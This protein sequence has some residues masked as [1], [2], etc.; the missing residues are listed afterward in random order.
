VD[1]AQLPAPQLGRILVAA[2]LLDEEQVAQAL[3]EQ[4]QTG[5]RLGEIIVQR[6]FI[7]G[8]ALANALAEQY[9]GVVKTEYG[10]ASGLGGVVA[11]RAASEAGTPVSP[12]RP[13]D[14]TPTQPLETAAL[15]AEPP[16]P[17]GEP[18]P[19]AEDT[20]PAEPEPTPLAEAEE[21]VPE[22]EPAEPVPDHR[23]AL[24]ESLHVRLEA[25]E[26]ELAKLRGELE[27]ERAR[28]DVQVNVWPEE[29]P[30]ATTPRPG[31]A[32]HYLLCVPTTAGYVLL[33]RVG[34]L[35][36]TGQAV[37]VPEEEGQFTV[38]KVVRLPRNGRPCAYLQRA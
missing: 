11:K 26:L 2:G 32:E 6:G 35:P 5:Q 28:K 25:Q 31:Q 13:P 10:F 27:H 21:P 17:A 20:G 23:D 14:P 33:D 12:L 4:A 38:A 1:A 36:S 29:Q 37:D 3:E 7:S 24:I 16:A 34:A 8:P 19:E 18:E 15:G 9:G 30:P 22:P